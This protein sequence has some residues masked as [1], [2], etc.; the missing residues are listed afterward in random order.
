MA[1][2]IR[3]AASQH[4][5]EDLQ[6]A[7]RLARKALPRSAQGDYL[8]SQRDP[9]AII[10]HQ[11]ESRL[12]HLIPLRIAR[13]AQSPFAFF[14]GTA[15]IMAHDL[16]D[17]PNTGELVVASGDAH[18]ANF[19]LFATPERRLTFELN[20]FDEVSTA[21]WEWDV[22]RLAVS[23]VLAARERGAPD[24]FA[25]TEAEAAVH[26]Y[27]TTMADLVA[28]TSL[29]RF[30]KRLNVRMLEEELSPEDVEFIDRTLERARR[31]TSEY[32][33]PRI[34]TSDASGRLQIVDDPPVL[35]HVPSLTVE[36]AQELVRDYLRSAR[37]DSAFL[38][39]Q[40]EL[41]DV[42]YRIVG[43]GSVGTRCLIL[44]FVGRA[45]EPLFLQIKEA[46]PSV[47]ETFG[48]APNLL[49]E[50]NLRHGDHEG[51]RVI[52]GQRILQTASDPFLG[53]LT[54]EDRDYYVRQFRD[55]KASV[56]LDD[57]DERAFNLYVRY[58]GMLLAR[59]HAQGPAAPFI[60]GY[61]GNGA[62]F[63]R[64]IA[65][66]AMA[67]AAQVAHDFEALQVAIANGRLPITEL[68]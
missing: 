66:W 40:F 9:V 7:G 36:A 54:H 26:A 4:R 33:L 14:R 37:T 62:R 19:G 29:D 1:D 13:M 42:A 24:D 50:L 18:I 22:K 52:T 8:P 15:A 28:V 46:G 48:G 12:E 39:K 10:E 51:F 47:L 55:M 41:V 63:P 27:Q 53:Y 35:T 59:G 34:T 16:R 3:A 57:L 38:L 64:A 44:L 17:Q 20:D 5:L 58:C 43:V 11:H 31:R 45:G 21:P 67:Y 2:T 61:L 30:Y 25:A 23:I 60:S 68:A 6:E 32:L 65:R 56:D 49:R